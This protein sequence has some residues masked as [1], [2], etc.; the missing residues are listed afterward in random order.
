M[1]SKHFIKQS[2]MKANKAKQE[3]AAAL[4]MTLVLLSVL[5]IIGISGSKTAVIETRMTTNSIEK[6]KSRIAAE[7]AINYALAEMNDFTME[8]EWLNTCG[9]NGVYDLRTDAATTCPDP[10]DDDD[11]I[12]ANN[13]S[14]WDNVIHVS[15]WN[16][17]NTTS[18]GFML[19]KLSADN[20]QILVN[21]AQ[22]TNPMSLVN[23]PQYVIA[24]NDAVLRPN[25]ENKYC[26]PVTIIGAAKGGL[27]SSKTYIQVNAI[28]ESGCFYP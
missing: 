23:A 9:L 10:D 25:S 26:F 12:E 8:V 18:H 15:D 1:K 21:T 28:P 7:S 13:Q 2:R 27:D 4:I 5:T 3:G 17:N 22:R 16:W 11:T 24:I 20:S 14:H 19:D 6:F